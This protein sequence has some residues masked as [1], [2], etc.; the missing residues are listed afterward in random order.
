MTDSAQNKILYPGPDAVLSSAEKK[1]PEEHAAHALA[2][3]HKQSLT[4]AEHE[5]IVRET[6]KYWT[7]HVNVGFLGYRKSVSDNEGTSVEW[8]DVEPGSCLFRD[9][10]GRLYI[11]CLG[12]FGIFNVGHRHPV[13]L[14]AVQ[15]QLNKQALHSQELLDPLRP[16]TAHLFSKLTPGNGAL[17]HFFFVNSGA[18]AV[19]AALKMALLHTGRKHIIATVNAFHGKTLGALSTTSKSLFRKPFLPLLNVT[20]APFNDSKYMEKLFKASKFSGNEIACI[21]LEPIQGEGGIYVACDEYLRTC[22]R[23]CDEYGAALIFD[24]V[25]SGMGRT[26]RWWGCEHAGVTPDLIAIGKAFGG[27]VQPAGACF[28]TAKIWEKYVEEPFIM[29]TTFGGNPLAMAAAI[30]TVNVIQQEGL[31][32]KA[33]TRGDQMMTGLR[34]L[35]AEFPKVI[36]DVRGRGLMIGVEFCNNDIGVMFSKGIFVRGVLVSGTL[37]NALVVRFEPPLTITE[38]QVNTVLNR[39]RETCQWI[40][41][42]LKEIKPI[43]SKL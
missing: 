38:E 19:E 36:A 17:S 37:I 11:D 23:L 30:A 41:S 34:K 40:M 7:D 16:Y 3:V 33:I 18:E 28:G 43:P 39:A 26:G 31:L 10:Q 42:E 12:G 20:H 14:A 22:R 4:T 15:A 27:G 24:E 13:V 2:V 29:T 9:T 8:N 35:K 5:L 6:V 1:T 25:Q 32:Q 21:I